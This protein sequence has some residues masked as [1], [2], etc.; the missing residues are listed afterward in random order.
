VVLNKRDEIIHEKTYIG[1]DAAS[2]LI[3]HLVECWIEWLEKLLTINYKMIFTKSDSQAYELSKKCYLCHDYFNDSDVTKRKNRDHDHYNGK[4]MG[5]SCTMCNLKRRRNKTLPIFLHN[6]SKYDFHFIIRAFNEKNVGDINILP[7]NGEHFR[8][9]EFLGFKFL[10]SLAFLQASLGQLSE[11]L[12]KTDHS[13]SILKQTNLVKTN[14]L[15]D[16]RKF[17]LLLKK[18]YYPY[19]YCTDLDRM[20]STRKLPKI[21]DFYSTLREETI[22]EKEYH[23]ARDV[24]R[25]FDCQDLLDYTKIYCKLDTILLAEI[26]QKF[27][28]DMFKFSNLDPA[29]YISLPSFAFDSMMKLTECELQCLPDIDMVHMIESGIRGGVSF[30]SHRHLQKSED[31]D[32]EIVYIDANVSFYFNFNL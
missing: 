24:W 1:N 16:K 4:F 12:S 23:I 22:D 25:K 17:D 32:D 19:E 20:E 6:G 7:Y 11:D 3:D 31:K 5:A 29:H 28:A 8:T 27:R 2:N 10:D 21:K 9:I 26:F 15:L 13:Y 18:S 30:I 14:G